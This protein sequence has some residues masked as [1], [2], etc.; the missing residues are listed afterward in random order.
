VVG[1]MAVAVTYNTFAVS[2]VVFS[3]T[4]EQEAAAAGF[5]LL[6]MMSVRY[7]PLPTSHSPSNKLTI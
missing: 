7:N 2:S 6:S 4:A 5:I 3:A 1:F